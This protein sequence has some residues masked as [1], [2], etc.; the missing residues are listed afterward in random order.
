[1]HFITW[2]NH[3]EL[4]TEMLNHQISYSMK[5]APLSYAILEYLADWL[6]QKQKRK[7]QAALHIWL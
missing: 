7:M 3:M 4:F 5:E 6:I 2:K 1:M